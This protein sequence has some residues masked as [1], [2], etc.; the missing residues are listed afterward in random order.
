MHHCANGCLQ[1]RYAAEQFAD[2]GNFVDSAQSRDS[3]A[4]SA[5]EAFRGFTSS[6]APSEDDEDADVDA[7]SVFAKLKD[8]KTD[9]DSDKG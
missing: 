5:D 2:T 9:Q 7:D 8:L 3:D 4:P 1:C 6:P